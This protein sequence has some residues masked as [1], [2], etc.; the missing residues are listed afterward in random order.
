MK[1]LYSFLLGIVLITS[2]SYSIEYELFTA[3]EGQK[4]LQ[5]NYNLTDWELF[6][7]MSSWYPGDTTIIFDFVNGTSSYWFYT[8]RP[9]GNDN[10]LKSWSFLLTKINGQYSP[11][12]FGV[13][14]D[15]FLVDYERL[16]QNWLDSDLLPMAVQANSNL[17]QF[18]M[19]H[20]QKIK[21]FTVLLTPKYVTEETYPKGMWWLNLEIEDLN[22][23]AYCIF[24]AT[25]LEMVECFVP[26]VNSTK[27]FHKN[28]IIS[29]PNPASDYIDIVLPNGNLNKIKIYNS[30]GDCVIVENPTNSSTTQRIYISNMPNGIYYLKIGQSIKPFVIKR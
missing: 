5:E 11:L 27:D 23:T 14:D 22:E 17:G 25:A 19:E 9:A 13:E 6:Q 4:F 12:D 20:F 21:E 2:Y 26:D 30:N 29:Y 10:M 15:E 7:A 16:P 28:T 1:K 3:G 18:L 24:E 8:F